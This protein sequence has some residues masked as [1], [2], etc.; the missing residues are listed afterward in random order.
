[1]PARLQP[2]LAQGSTLTLPAALQCR[3]SLPHQL[4][5]FDAGKITGKSQPRGLT[6]PGNHS[7]QQAAPERADLLA[8]T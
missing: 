3:V 1:M 2:R 6:Q 7:A 8:T 5:P 4:R